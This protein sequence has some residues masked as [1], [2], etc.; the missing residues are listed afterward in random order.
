M[1]RAGRKQWLVAE[2]MGRASWKDWREWL[3]EQNDDLPDPETLAATWDDMP[4]LAPP[5]IEGVLRQG[6]KMLLA[7]PS[8]AGKSFAL[9]GLTVSLAEGLPWF[10]WRCAQGRVMYVNLELDRHP[11][12]TASATSTP[13]WAPSRATWTTCA[14]GTCAASPSRWTSWRRRSYAARPRSAPSP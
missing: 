5:L 11:A 13:P 10:G 3:D 4:E 1:E 6:H 12:C 14:S 8:K 2:S 7:G 9:I